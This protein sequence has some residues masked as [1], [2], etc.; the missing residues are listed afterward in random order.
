MRHGLTLVAIWLGTQ[1]YSGVGRLGVDSMIWA[2]FGSMCDG[3]STALYDALS[4][5]GLAQ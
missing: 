1:E 5:Y 4:E 3:R 2:D